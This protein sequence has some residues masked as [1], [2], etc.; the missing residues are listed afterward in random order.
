MKKPTI[1]TDVTTD[2]SKRFPKTPNRT[3]ARLIMREQPGLFDTLEQARDVVR[4]VRGAKGKPRLSEARDKKEIG[5]QSAVMPKSTAEKRTPYRFP[6]PSRVFVMSDIHFP[7]HDEQALTAAVKWGQ[8]KNP[9]HVLLN[10]DTVENYGVSRWE[11]DPRRRNV[12]K[13]L[14]EAKNGIRWIRR[15]FPKAEIVFKP[16]N[17]EDRMEKYLITN[18][19][20]LLGVEDFEMHRL[21]DL[22]ACN[23]AHIGSKQIVMAGKLAIIHGHEL[24]KGLT[25]SVNPA[26]G[27]YLKLQETSM[28]GH[29]HQ[30]S[31]HSEASGL[32]KRNTTC[33]STGCLCDLSP[34][35][36]I[37]NRWNHGCAFVDVFK[38][39]TFRVENVK[40]IDGKV[41]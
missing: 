21:L 15:M 41:Y 28:C 31:E 8:S 20:A 11:P 22:D 18:A 4:V 35:F 17:H 9:T 25:S 32:K 2:Y 24:P 3:L 38:D 7:F 13:E 14:K 23:I 37:V 10:G 6:N 12:A 5:W 26:R 29:F 16:G 1:K 30:T 19:A 40:I 39:G 34:E 33:Y 36:C 27:L